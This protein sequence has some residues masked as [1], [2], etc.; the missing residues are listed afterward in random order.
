MND[1][2]ESATLRKAKI[3]ETMNR[4][5]EAAV[6]HLGE[7]EAH[8]LWQQVGSRKRGRPSRPSK[9]KDDAFLLDLYDAVVRQVGSRPDAPRKI[10]VYCYES[11][12]KRFGH[13]GGADTIEKHLRRLL[14][15]RTKSERDFAAH[16]T[17]ASGSMRVASLI[18]DVAPGAA[19]VGDRK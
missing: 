14:K 11:E 7:D 15:E 9:P 4:L 5:F 12:K 6:N 16:W 3:V 8:Q 10:A 2:P 19:G 18:G 17:G 1:T 13:R